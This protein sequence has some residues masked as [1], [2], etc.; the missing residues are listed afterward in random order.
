MFRGKV[1]TVHFVGIGGVGMSGLAEVLLDLGFGVAGSDAQVNEATARL[2]SLG[3]NIFE[4]H[5]ASHIEDV[6]VVVTSSAIPASNAELVEA[7]RRNIPVIARAEML[8]ELMRLKDGIAIAGSHGKTTTT[9]LVATILQHAK[10]DPTVVIGGRV[11]A[12]GT[13][14]SRGGGEFLVAEADESDGSFLQ[15]TPTIAV[16][17]NIDPEHL[18]H[19]GSHDQLK[20][21]FATFA[22]RVPFYGTVIACMD[23]PDVQ[24][25]L[26]RIEKR[27]ITYGTSTQADFRASDIRAEGVTS[28]FQLRRK[29]GG[30]LDTVRIPLPGAHNVMNALAAIAT[31]DE[32][33]VPLA[34]AQEA[35]RT[36]S[37][38]HRRFTILD[39]NSSVTVVDDYAHHPAEIVSTLRAAQQAYQR[40]VLAVF[41]PH[42]YT[43][44][45]HLFEELTKS[46]NYADLVFML[47]VYPAGEEP[48]EGARSS[49]LTVGVR[50]RG[51]R[52]ASY[53]PTFDDALSA[54]EQRLA[55]DDVVLLLG[56][57][58]VGRL[59]PLVVE[60]A[61]RL[62][63]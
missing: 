56:A 41:Q 51:H 30:Q 14:A 8:G 57:G 1:R 18:D 36:F 3:A 29:A 12:L 52:G 13:G 25:I 19:F 11:N 55:S 16:L 26:P 5:H 60:L 42:R 21:A 45:H 47:D 40:R 28:I 24:E 49:D 61:Q 4:G 31:A 22:N 46:F 6:D 34:V 37:G 62:R 32:V 43:R 50:Q 58:S 63:L 33:G 44:T 10:L 9:S 15:L 48:I 23:H 27:V 20:D 59:V 7:K 54:L 38:V 2:R 53:T 17:T 39:T 35:L